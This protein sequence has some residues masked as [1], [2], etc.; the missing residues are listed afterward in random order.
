MCHV[1]PPSDVT[2][3]FYAVLQWG[4]TYTLVQSKGSWFDK[5]RTGQA[6]DLPAPKGGGVPD[7][8]VAELVARLQGLEAK[9]VQQE[10]QQKQQLR[11]QQ[12]NQQQQQL[13]E[14]QRPGKGFASR[15]DPGVLKDGGL[16]DS[17][18]F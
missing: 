8:Q 7:Q 2:A 11:Q 13:R 16:G 14:Q 4:S 5:R 3:L 1:P 15:A 17:C 6:P 18:Y 9:L 12:Q 10:Q